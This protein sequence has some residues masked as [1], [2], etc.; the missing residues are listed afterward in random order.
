VRTWF[1]AF[2]FEFNLYRLRFGRSTL[3]RVKEFTIPGPGEYKAGSALTDSRAVTGP[4]KSA[5]T[6]PDPNGNKA[7][8][9]P[10]GPAFYKPASVSKKSFH[11]NAHKRFV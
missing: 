9:L 6:R 11:L 1:Q 2:A 7:E 3:N 10:P 8:L 4:F 5:S